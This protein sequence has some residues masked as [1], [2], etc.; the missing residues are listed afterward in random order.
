MFGTLKV[1]EV[2]LNMDSQIQLVFLKL[3][4]Y[5]AKVENRVIQIRKPGHNH[6][7]SFSY[8]SMYQA[9]SGKEE[10]MCQFLA[11]HVLVSCTQ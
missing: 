6:M 10:I 4:K 9:T 1:T 3:F 11:I 7:A 8:L 5:F 2:M